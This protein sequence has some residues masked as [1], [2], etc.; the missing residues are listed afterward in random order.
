MTNATDADIIELLTDAGL[1]VHDGYVKANETAK[2]ISVSFPYVVFWSSPGFDNDER[3]AGPV[4]GRVA[5]FQL[6]GV[7]VTREQAKWAL[8]KARTAISRKRLDGALIRRNDDNAM[9]RRDDEYTRPG[10]G[11]LFYGVDR[12]G[13]AVTV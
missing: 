7:G 11:P 8:D 5:E 3:F 12:Y 1:T 9:V 10:G 4:N 2:E 6:T 13:V